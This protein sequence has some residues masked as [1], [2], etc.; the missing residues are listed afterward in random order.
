MESKQSP[1]MRA[2]ARIWTTAELL[3]TGRSDEQIRTLVRRGK[4]V[5]VNRGFYVQLLRR[6]DET[7]APSRELLVNAAAAIRGLGP[8]A[9]VSHHTAA[10]IHGL[11]LLASAENTVAVT[12]PPD[13]G[14]R[15]GKPGVRLRSAG[16]PA[17]HVTAKFGIPV[18]TVARTVVDLA[19]LTPF[20]EGLVV[21]D[22]ALHAKQVTK[23]ELGAVLAECRQWPGCQRAAGV[24]Q[25]AD[26]RSESVLESISRVA[27]RD[28]GLPAPDLQIWIGDA[29]TAIGRVD[30]FW[31]AFKTVAEADGALKYDTR[32][33]AV[34][35]LHRDERMREAG[36]EIVHFGWWDITEEPLRVASAIRL[37]FERG[38][39]NG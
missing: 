32:H 35:Q 38:S 13:T 23:A 39:R 20:R 18:T 8:R 31:P 10:L 3:A 26:H 19:R 15:T 22:S 17:R 36:F 25:F 11:N 16:L 1:D 14:S 24:I 30:F 34:A 7:K 37:A 28:C 2:L 9:V 5:R 6:I 33:Q 21:A 29:R 4:L 27:F 12:R